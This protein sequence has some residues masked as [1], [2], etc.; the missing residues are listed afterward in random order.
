MCATGVFHWYFQRT[1]N[2]SMLVCDRV[3]LFREQCSP[4]PFGSL[5]LSL[6]WPPQPAV[7][8]HEVSSWVG[9]QSERVFTAW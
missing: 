9:E 8:W 6:H 7:L 4:D 3:A 2:A 5:W 1:Q